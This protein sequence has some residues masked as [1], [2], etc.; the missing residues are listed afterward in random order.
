MKGLCMMS[1]HNSTP[2]SSEEVD[3]QIERYL[4]ASLADSQEQ[5]AQQT[6][7]SLQRLYHIRSD[8]QSPSLQRVWQR[9]LAQTDPETSL[10][11]QP[12]SGLLSTL[13]ETPRQHHRRPFTLFSQLA[14]VF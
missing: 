1:H 13:H 5:A 11:T 12:G 10:Q 3:Q 2:F 7:Q 14:A 9:V 6:V 8:P 4:S